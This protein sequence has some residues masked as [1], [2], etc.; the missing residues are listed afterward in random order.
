VSLS[1]IQLTKLKSELHRLNSSHLRWK[2]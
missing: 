2:L 1:L